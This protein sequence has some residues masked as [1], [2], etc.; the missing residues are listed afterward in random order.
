MLTLD[1]T[2]YRVNLLPTFQIIIFI[3]CT[4]IVSELV[5][6]VVSK[7]DDAAGYPG[8]RWELAILLIAPILFPISKLQVVYIRGEDS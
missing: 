1:I 8:T 5:A 3:Y 2:I 7:H 6:L 4:N